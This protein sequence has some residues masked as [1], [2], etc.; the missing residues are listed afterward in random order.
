MHRFY[1]AFGLV[2]LLTLCGCDANVKP[3]PVV[4]AP[5]PSLDD[6]PLVVH[7]EY[8]NWSKF[9]VGTEVIRKDNLASSEG[10]VILHTALRLA[11]KSDDGVTIETLT[12]IERD[13][14]RQES[15]V[16]SADYVA[17]FRLPKG[18]ELE[19]F[20]LPA[21][22]AKRVGEEKVTVADQEVV[23]EVFGFEDQSEAGPVDVTLWRSSEIPGRQVKKEIVD[24]KGVVLSS[25][26]ISAIVQPR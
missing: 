9:P 11:K 1:R 12:A 7:P 22:K 13:G 3:V 19:Q 25:S 4:V 23:C 6:L 15:D 20:Q 16:T 2:C 14:V 5:P 24:R 8:D 17:K 10:E 21:L 18:M 26:R